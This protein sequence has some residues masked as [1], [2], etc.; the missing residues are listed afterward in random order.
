MRTLCIVLLLAA[1][2]PISGT[3]PAVTRPKATQ[4]VVEPTAVPSR[5][6]TAAEAAPVQSAQPLTPDRPPTPA[7]GAVEREGASEA[8]LRATLMALHDFHTRHS[9]SATDDPQ[10]GIGAAREWLAA[11]FQSISP[12]LKVER[13]E[14]VFSFGARP[15]RAQNIIATLPGLAE[16]PQIII[17]SAHYDSRTVNISDNRSAAPGANDDGSGVAAVLE[18]ARLLSSEKLEATV[19]FVLF[20]GEEE[21]LFG[22]AHLAPLMRKQGVD[23]VA[24]LNN[25]IIGNVTGADGA[26]VDDRVRVFSGDPD[27]GSSR[28][29]AYEA[30]R[31]IEGELRGLTVDVVPALD[32]PGRGGDHIPFYYAG[33]PA[34][35]FTE[36][37][38][39]LD[40][41]H[42]ANDR[43]EFMDMAYLAK[44]VRANLAVAFELGRAAHQTKGDCSN[45]CK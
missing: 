40:H 9:A 42:S 35:R 28:Q 3:P 26:R 4:P 25:D 23:I 41:Q 22:S 14:F 7:S 21:G 44:V 19:M 34:I 45:E 27:G 15:V 16:P 1:C 5:P 37:V 10:T 2:A 39:N 43:V 18:L 12:R 11:Q 6:T 13:D 31:I 32:R 38:E 30:K 24:M 8:R 17:I 29:L 36:A 20:A 33:F